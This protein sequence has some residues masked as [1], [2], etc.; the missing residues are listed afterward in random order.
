MFVLP[1]I[2]IHCPVYFCDCPTCTCTICFIWLAAW[3]SGKG[4]GLWLAD[5]PWYAPDLW[6]TCDHFVA[7]ASA[8][9]QPTRPT[10]PPIL[11]GTGNE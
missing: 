9:G 11:S 5:F 7:K 6:L 3:L 2:H 4:V 10:Q 1:Y 8:V